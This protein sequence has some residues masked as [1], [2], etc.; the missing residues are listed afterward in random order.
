MN[1]RL[2]LSAAAVLPLAACAGVE[3]DAS[4]AATELSLTAGGVKATYGIIMGIAGVAALAVPALGPVVTAA[5]VAL[6]APMAAIEADVATAEQLASA[7]AALTTLLITV[8]PNMTAT[9][10]A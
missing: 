5:Q 2:L 3:A 7:S 9:G 4:K 1:R 6:A 10:H 8:A